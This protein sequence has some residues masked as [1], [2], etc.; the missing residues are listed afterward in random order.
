MYLGPN[1]TRT[2]RM[3]F[4]R[5]YLQEQVLRAAASKKLAGKIVKKTNLRLS[6]K[7]EKSPQSASKEPV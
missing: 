2:D 1:L 4:F 6:R 5:E 3:R 7:K